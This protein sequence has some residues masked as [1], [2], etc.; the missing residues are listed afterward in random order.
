MV[1]ISYAHCNNDQI[2]HDDDLAN[3]TWIDFR[4]AECTYS[5]KDTSVGDLYGTGELDTL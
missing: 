3:V 1:G 5:D 2:P 4:Q